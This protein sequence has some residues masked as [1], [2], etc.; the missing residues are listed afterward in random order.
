MLTGAR[1]GASTLLPL[2]AAAT[3]IAGKCVTA[4]R[5][6]NHRRVHPSA[7]AMRASVRPSVR[8][9]VLSDDCNDDDDDELRLLPAVGGAADDEL[10][11]GQQ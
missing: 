9:S 8:P 11:K 7:F 5:I 6:Q 10:R 1:R 2:P 3:S 4:R